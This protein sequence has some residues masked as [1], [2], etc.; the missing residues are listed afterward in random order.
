MSEQSFSSRAKMNFYIFSILGLI[1]FFIPVTIGETNTILIDHIVNL[2]KLVLGDAVKY[3]V[4]LL[5][6]Y[7]II[8][9]VIKGTWLKSTTSKVMFV[10]K[11]IGLIF[12][13][14]YIFALGPA[15]IHDPGN[16]PF[17]FNKLAITLTL[18]IPIGGMLLCLITGYGLMEFIGVFARPVM[19]PV[20]KSPG[21]SAIDAVA[22]FVGSYSI[23]L[24]ITNAQYEDN[25][26]TKKEAAIIA[27]GF[28][29]VSATFMVV[30]AKTL[31]LMDMW[32]TYFTVTMVITFIVTAI[33]IRLYPLA[34]MEDVYMDGSPAVSDKIEGGYLKTAF[35]EGYA[36]AENSIGILENLKKSLVD[37]INIGASV[38]PTI[39][40]IGLIGL[41]VGEYT[42]VF[43]V[44]GYIYYPFTALLGFSDP[45]LV[46][47]ASSISIVEMFLPA[48]LAQDG[49]F[50]TRFTIGVVCVSEV[51]FFSASI[52]CILSTKIPIKIKDIV[53]VWF[54]RVVLTLIIT[55]PI[56]HLLA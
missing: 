20:F 8:R 55:A 50:V 30:V 41:L 47:K 17:L 16:L 10:F 38:V 24:L 53:I 18:V 44:L 43:D 36:A 23:G 22:S 9:E 52:P 14:M 33:T 1:L 42:K 13:I 5:I 39:L 19:R 51:L 25:K 15:V 4:I 40:S 21:R 46:A 34:K 26:Y 49:D 48:A 32:L 29:T 7:G 31:G 2:V 37:G 35:N 27:T 6:A 28:S 54:L 56:A 11:V 45:M 3:V 12:G